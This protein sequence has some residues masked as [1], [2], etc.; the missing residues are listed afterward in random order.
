MQFLVFFLYVEPAPNW[1][2]AVGAW[3]RSHRMLALI[4]MV[5]VAWLFLRDLYFQSFHIQLGDQ[6]LVL[7]RRG[8]APEKLAW[9]E[10]VHM[11]LLP[12]RLWGLLL[13]MNPEPVPEG[14]RTKAPLGWEWGR[15]VRRLLAF[16]PDVLLIARTG[17]YLLLPL[18]AFDSETY[19]CL[20]EKIKTQSACADEA[21]FTQSL[22]IAFQS[23]NQAQSLYLERRWDLAEPLYRR[24]A[25]HWLRAGRMD[26]YKR[27]LQN[28]SECL[29]T[30]GR[31]TEAAGILEESLTL[32]KNSHD[33]RGEANTRSGL[34][35]VGWSLGEKSSI[36]AAI[37]H[38]DAARKIHNQLGETFYEA[39]MLSNL[40]LNAERL[41]VLLEDTDRNQAALALEQCE[42]Y[43][44]DGLRLLEKAPSGTSPENYS[45]QRANLMGTLAR[46]LFLQGKWRESAELF[47]SAVSLTK[48]K[49]IL[50]DQAVH[51]RAVFLSSTLPQTGEIERK[52]L[53]HTALQILDD[54]VRD[55]PMHGDH[56]EAMEIMIV[57]GDIYWDM[58]RWAEALRDYEWVLELV[59]ERD[60]VLSRSNERAM[61]R[62]RFRTLFPRLVEGNLRLAMNETDQGANNAARAFW[63]SERFKGSSLA[64]MLVSSSLPASL[65]KEA[66]ERLNEAQRAQKQAF[67][68][69]EAVLRQGDQQALSEAWGILRKTEERL[70]E[71]IET[72]L[73]EAPAIARVLKR[74]VPSFTEVQAELPDRS[75]AVL[76]FSLCEAGLAAFLVSQSAPPEKA[77]WF[78]PGFT[79]TRCPEAVKRFVDKYAEFSTAA[80]NHDPAS[81]A[82][83]ADWI[84]Y[85]PSL[86]DSI[87][88]E[89]FD[90]AG[91]HGSIC[92]KLKELG[93]SRLAIVPEGILNRLPVHAA[94]PKEVCVSLAPSSAILLSASKNVIL[95]PPDLLVV[96]PPQLD[97]PGVRLE[98]ALIQSHARSAGIVTSRLQG[99]SAAPAAILERMQ[100]APWLHYSGHAFSSNQQAW[101]SGLD[102]GDEKRLMARMILERGALP[103]G[104]VLVVNG[105]SSGVALQDHAGEVA[106]LPVAFLALGCSV[107]VSTLWE[108]LQGP[109]AILMDRFYSKLWSGNQTHVEALHA[110][111]NELRDMNV[112]DV[113]QYE[114]SHHLIRGSLLDRSEALQYP[115]SHPL[116]W[117]AHVVWG[118]AWFAPEHSLQV[119]ETET[120]ATRVAARTV[121]F[122]IGRGISEELRETMNTAKRF[123][124]E[125]QFDKAI[126]LHEELLERCGPN[127]L[128]LH[129]LAEIHTRLQNY[130]RAF[131]FDRQ[132]LAMDVNCPASHYILGCDLMD[133][134]RVAEAR[135]Y[136][137]RVLFLDPGYAKAL[138]NLAALS[139]DAE[140]VLA[141]LR[142]AVEIDPEDEQ[143]RLAIDHWAGITREENFNLPEYRL[144]GIQSTLEQRDWKAMRIQIGLAR[145]LPLSTQQRSYTCSAEAEMYRQQGKLRNSI[146]CLEAALE[147]D[148]TLP[149]FWNTLSA[150]RYLLAQDLT[151][152]GTEAR[153]LLE[154]AVDAGR[155]AIRR[156]DYSIPHRNLALAYQALRAWDAAQ[157]EANAAAAM[158]RRQIASG[159]AGPLVCVGCAL[160]GQDLR[161]CHD[162]VT[163]AESVLESGAL[164]EGNYRV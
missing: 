161:A 10:I 45:S 152:S 4:G 61:L 48:R 69:A 114:A 68:R 73:D 124:D 23:E 131:E 138:C 39:R 86:I 109:A 36:Q 117:A 50:A 63:F 154:A 125:D 123:F 12:P 110:A 145:E 101:E 148:D 31:Y 107:V 52:R 150:R 141:L 13:S 27:V 99:G 79:A 111:L 8:A 85:L 144:H 11:Q 115:P 135:T 18:G 21:T 71:A 128:L 143:T 127:R 30:M 41:V 56:N 158:A 37:A 157:T 60:Y 146:A 55:L 29:I 24:T 67:L 20:R 77:F 92:D 91:P 70:R 96:D 40:A 1:L 134:G 75:T 140:Q 82:L 163:A 130:E 51:A 87:R 7:R 108:V 59:D 78:I 5:P 137:H 54:A 83:R 53:I 147:W 126:A 64:E 84:A 46:C 6:H 57:R 151:T 89:I 16:A 160:R 38:L 156:G 93:I 26:Q 142:Q 112:T 15:Q 122:E 35:K 97:L 34:G 81:L 105:C 58:G 136:F 118:A 133:L 102:S 159:P 119:A 162:C 42:H 88:E 9:A 2:N 17:K 43:A 106:G 62:R 65:G 47:A 164:T 44:K 132:A 100:T 116:N 19:A 121:H 129:R 25:E 80:E 32:C 113:W 149:P 74:R 72:V 153:E 94:V 95:K 103:P 120:L 98:A 76:Q 3:I 33:L 139:N 14:R 49:K 22:E 155:E 28:W 104:A 90:A 66:R